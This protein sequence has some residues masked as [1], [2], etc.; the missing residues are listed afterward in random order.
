MATNKELESRVNGIDER[1]AGQKD[2]LN[3]IV[4]KLNAMSPA[5]GPEPNDPQVPPAPSYLQRP[6]LTSQTSRLVD[7]GF[8]FLVG[9]VVLLVFLWVGG[10]LQR[11]SVDPSDNKGPIEIVAQAHEDAG[12]NFLKLASR[13]DS[14]EE[15]EVIREIPTCMGDAINHGTADTVSYLQRVN[16]AGFDRAK[17]KE[18]IRYMGEV[19]LE[20]AK[21]LRK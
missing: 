1:I 8:A 6:K 20:S 17:T 5:A 16:A 11:H 18:T 9:I 7:L 10:F 4:K 2:L 21:K 12:N 13:I 15:A 14:M 19:L 3:K